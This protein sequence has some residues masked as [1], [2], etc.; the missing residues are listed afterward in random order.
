MDNKEFQD[1]LA[2]YPNEYIICM[3]N[4]FGWEREHNLIDPHLYINTDI[5]QIEIEPDEFRSPWKFIKDGKYPED[6]ELIVAS[7]ISEFTNKRMYETVYYP[8][9]PLT[10]RMDKWFHIPTEEDGF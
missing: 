1:I 3:D 10:D 9:S 2:Q 8:D 7:Y 6:G 4:V 5:G